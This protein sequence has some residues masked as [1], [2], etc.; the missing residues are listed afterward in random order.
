VKQD[1]IKNFCLI[2]YEFIIDRL[3]IDRRPLRKD[4]NDT[5]AIFSRYLREVYGFKD[6]YETQTDALFDILC[7]TFS[8]LRINRGSIDKK[9]IE[10][11]IVR[12]LCR[13]GWYCNLSIALGY[14]KIDNGYIKD[15]DLIIKR[16]NIV[17]GVKKGFKKVKNGWRR[18]YL[19]EFL[20]SL[21]TG[22]KRCPQCG[23]HMIANLAGLNGIAC[24]KCGY[25]PYVTLVL[26][27]ECGNYEVIKAQPEL[28]DDAVF[29]YMNEFFKKKITLIVRNVDE[30]C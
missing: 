14:K 2:D 11:M 5:R 1:L 13:S 25:N 4:D 22:G 9:S 8:L 26:F 24:P 18:A 12:E 20:L 15:N 29:S 19:K 7:N 17:S 30:N 10:S 28:T 6:F 3:Y 27:C 16:A 21:L 23:H